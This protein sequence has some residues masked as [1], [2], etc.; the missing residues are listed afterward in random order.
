M[1]GVAHLDEA[2]VLLAG[3]RGHRA[4]VDVAVVGQDADGLAVEP[5][6]AGDLARPVRGAELEEGVEVHD[7]AHDLAH[8]ETGVGVP[9]YGGEQVLLHP[10]RIVLGR[11][12]RRTLAD[13]RGQVAQKAPGLGEGG[14][15]VFDDVVDDAACRVHVGAAEFVL[16]QAY[17]EGPLHQGRAADE[18]LGG[19]ARHH[20][21]V[22]RDHAAGREP[23][24]RAAGDGD[25]RNLAHRVRDDAKSG[26]AENRFA[27]RAAAPPAAL[28]AAAAAFEHAHQR[29]PVL[30]GEVFGV[31]ALAQ[32]GRVRGTALEREVLAAHHDAP[33]VDLAEAHDVV[34]RHEAGEVVVLVVLRDGGRLAVLLERVGVQERVD[35]LADRQPA[36]GVLFRDALV[37]ALLFREMPPALDLADFL[38]PAHAIQVSSTATT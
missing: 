3:F 14:V 34:R 26:H 24:D 35:A 29:H 16:G 22:R 1:E 27:D 33:V 37:A 28:H 2:P 11:D 38:L 5:R 12:A 17:A 4:R 15:L 30:H 7:H 23:R 31:D 20:G 18:D 36:A 32:S 25:D 8:V 9:R 21:E 13:A 10:L 6:E 19:V